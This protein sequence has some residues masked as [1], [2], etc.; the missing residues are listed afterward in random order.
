M[1]VLERFALNGKIAIVTGANRGLGRAIAQALAEAG[2]QVALAARRIESAQM[3]AAEIQTD[4]GQTCRGYA[5]D[6]TNTEQITA[7]VNSVL[8]DFG[9]IDIIVNNAGININRPIEELSLE[10]FRSVQDTNLTGAWWLCHEVAAHFKTRQTGRI[11]NIASTSAIA[12][13]PGLTPYAS[14]KA[15]M[16]QMTRALARELGPFNVT[17][18]SILPGPIVTDM[19][20]N[21]RQ[22]PKIN[23][24]FLAMMPVRRWGEPYEVGALAVFLASEAAGFITG[25][26]IV[27]DGGRTA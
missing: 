20:E 14:S 3:A 1:K 23:Q 24:Q 2:A 12:A 10:E 13:F 5:C 18:N 21:A 19:N 11:I 4:T 17:A 26:S 15:G 7:L 8:A 27:I 9:Q 22:D 6:V 16:V 25:A